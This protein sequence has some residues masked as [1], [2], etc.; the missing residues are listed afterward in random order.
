MWKEQRAKHLEDDK[1]SG[2]EERVAVSRLLTSSWVMDPFVNPVIA[3]NPLLRR[4]SRLTHSWPI[5]FLLSLLAADMWLPCESGLARSFD[6]SGQVKNTDYYVDF[7]IFKV[8]VL[9]K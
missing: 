9:T 3:L 4:I 6:F 7:F 8:M 2:Q 1:L 5:S